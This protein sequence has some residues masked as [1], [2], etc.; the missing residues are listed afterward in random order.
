MPEHTTLLRNR[1]CYT[2]SSGKRHVVLEVRMGRGI[3]V[4]PRGIVDFAG[5]AIDMVPH[6]LPPGSV[7]PFDRWK[8]VL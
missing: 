3:R 2:L 7:P 1:N 5:L 4:A 6:L 8:K